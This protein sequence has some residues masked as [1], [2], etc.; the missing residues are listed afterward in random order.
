[1]SDEFLEALPLAQRLALSYAPAASRSA[2]LTLLM[3]DNRLAD[4][5]R[6]RGDEAIIAQMKLAWWRDRFAAYPAQWPKGEPLL[7]RLREWPG[8]V[9]GLAALVDGWEAL[10]A[11]QLGEGQWAEFAQGRAQAWAALADGLELSDAGHAIETAAREWALAD[12]AIHLGDDAEGQA[13]RAHAMANRGRVSRLPRQMRP[14]KVLHGL[15]L[16]AL[17]RNTGDLLDGPG[18]VL[19][20]M[21][22]GIAG[23]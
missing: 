20:A 8:D 1:M 3:L 6:Q 17:S 11:E 10:L 4:V 23:R 14:L 9:S 15:S 18:A 22:L 2:T 13:A 12:L 19:A 21:R 5:L 16:R 7:A